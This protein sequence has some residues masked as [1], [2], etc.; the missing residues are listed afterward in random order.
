MGVDL[1]RTP[2]QAYDDRP[3]QG[4][5]SY[6]A[7]GGSMDQGQAS[8]ARLSIQNAAAPNTAGESNN[9]SLTHFRCCLLLKQFAIV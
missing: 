7:D 1:N 2:S 5:G 9:R 3:A 4:R 8:I 6:V